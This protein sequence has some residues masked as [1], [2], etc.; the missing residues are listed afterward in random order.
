ML[1]AFGIQ[2]YLQETPLKHTVSVFLNKDVA[3]PADGVYDDIVEID[4]S[5]PGGDTELSN[6]IFEFLYGLKDVISVW[7]GAILS[8]F[9]VVNLAR[10]G[11]LMAA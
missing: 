2:F 1:C 5:W 8:T 6:Q 11:D 4:A 7:F 9:L 3:E 10:F